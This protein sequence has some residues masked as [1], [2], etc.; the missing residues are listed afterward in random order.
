MPIGEESETT[1]CRSRKQKNEPK[2]KYIEQNT[3]K[4]VLAD[5]NK[6]NHK[7]WRFFWKYSKYVFKIGNLLIKVLGIFQNKLFSKYTN[8]YDLSSII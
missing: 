1:K 2:M 6:S 3:N 7:E 8:L 4:I 5:S